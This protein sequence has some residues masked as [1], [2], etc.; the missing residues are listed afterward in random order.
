[1]DSRSGTAAFAADGERVGETLMSVLLGDCLFAQAIRFLDQFRECR[2]QPRAIARAALRNFVR[3]NNS[4]AKRRFDLH[5]A[6]EESLRII[7]YEGR[8]ALRGRGRTG[9]RTLNRAGPGLFNR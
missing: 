5:L 3:A 9:R 7:G 1:M 6:I 2:D 8:L 4:N